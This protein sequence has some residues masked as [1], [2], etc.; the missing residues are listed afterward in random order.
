MSQFDSL[1]RKIIN[2]P[3]I[4][5]DDFYYVQFYANMKNDLVTISDKK[6]KGFD[7]FQI[8]CRK[9]SKENWDT[10]YCEQDNQVKQKLLL[11]FSIV[12]TN[13]LSL[14]F[15]DGCISLQSLKK[16]L[17]LNVAI[18]KAIIYKINN[19][20]KENQEDEGH[21]QKLLFEFRRL[22]NSDKGIVLKYKQIGQ[23]LHLC[24]FYEKLGLNY[25]DLQKLPYDVYKQLLMMI[26]IET[27]IKNQQIRQIN[28][29][30]K[31]SSRGRR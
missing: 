11:M 17:S 19:Y 3:F 20:Y 12:E 10:I 22:Y 18:V 14:T 4:K 30:A 27:E 13:F 31:Q 8:K 25:F 29:K 9:L 2:K 15:E 21:R 24:S 1:Y 26:G 16:I 23:Y 28:K 6:E 5:F 7:F